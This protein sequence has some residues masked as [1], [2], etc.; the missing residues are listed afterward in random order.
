MKSLALALFAAG[1]AA[2]PAAWAASP[3]DSW[4]A[5]A[6]G[7]VRS[8]SPSEV[9]APR[10]QQ[11]IDNPSTI[12][13]AVRPPRVPP[14]FSVSLFASGLHQPRVLRTAPDGDVFLAESGAGRVLYFAKGD[15]ATGLAKP[16]VFAAGLHRPYGIA[17]WPQ[18]PDPKWVYV[19]E[20][21]RVV[22]FAYQP[23]RPAAGPAQVV[24]SGIPG[25]HHWTRDIVDAPG[26]K[27]LFLAV[28]SGS[29]IAEEMP[30]VPPGG[31]AHW[32]ASHP[33]GEAWGPE[34][35]RAAVRLFG[36]DG[37]F[38]LIWATGLRNCSGMAV[39]P[40]TGELWCVVNERD[41]LGDDTPPDYATH[42]QRGAFYGWPW[43]YIG[44]HPD[45]RVGDRADLKGKVTVPDVLLEAH[46]APLGI[47]FYDA[48]QFP[49]EWRGDA[50][51]TEHGS[52]NRRKRVG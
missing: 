34:A 49:A 5:D 31:V 8:Y 14:G 13:H 1:L 35:G 26:G 50:F 17:F 51:V 18:G 38:D 33:L 22:R 44:D 32:A 20:P 9:P 2:A 43:Y 29:N 6:P 21:T 10:P 41:G 12:V 3:F 30:K 39:Q 46:V 28:G 7:V 47:A 37:R 40:G 42:V 45:A 25:N 24:L 36:P 27:A 16:R 19:G 4:Q 23:G 11:S 52:W 48:S 15:G